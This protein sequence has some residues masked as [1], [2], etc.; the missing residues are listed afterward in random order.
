MVKLSHTMIYCVTFGTM[1]LPH[2][3][4]VERPLLAVI[5]LVCFRPKADVQIL[6]YYLNHQRD[7]QDNAVHVVFS[8]EA[9]FYRFAP[10]DNE[11]NLP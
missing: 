9:E 10:I 3:S 6:F 2:N 8:M 1:R 5:G 7:N 11:T 4:T